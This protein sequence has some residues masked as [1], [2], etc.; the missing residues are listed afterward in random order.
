MRK[1]LT[2]IL[3]LQSIFLFSQTTLYVNQNV[4]GGLQNGTNWSDA[5][6][7]LQQALSVTTIGDTIWVAKGIYYPTTTTDRSIFF[8]LKNG[9]KMYGGF[10][11]WE[12]N[13]TQRDIELNETTLS[14][15][16]GLPQGSDNSYHVLYGE[17]LDS[18][19]VLDGFVI[20]KGNA[21]GSGVESMGGGL[22]LRPSPGI[23]NT[24]PILQN[25]RFE[26]NYAFS[27]GAISCER[28]DL[29]DNFINP[30]IINCQ[31]ISNR[32]TFSG[33]A[34]AKIGPA[35]LGQPFIM[36]A[37]VFSKNNA[38]FGDGG[39]VF[40]SRTE[41]ATILRHCVFEKDTGKIALGGGMH[42]AS[43]YEDF[44]T[45][46]T[47]ILDSCIFK[48]NIATMGGGF[49]YNDGSS[50]TNPIPF[51]STLLGCV[52]E[53]NTTTNG[54]GAAFCFMGQAQ[55]KL[56][57][58]VNSC[59][60]NGNLS[61]TFNITYFQ[62]LK[63]SNSTLLIKNCN[64]FNNKRLENPSLACF[65]IE[66]GIGGT[67]GRFEAKIENCL[68]AGNGGGISSLCNST[69]GGVNTYISNCTFYNNNEYIF[70][71]S[72]YPNFNG[73]DHYA[74]TYVNNCVIW[75][76]EAGLWTMFSDNDFMI[77]KLDG[78]H[79]DNCLLSL[80]SSITNFYPIFGDH[81][82]SET[83]PLFVDAANR[84]FRLET[85]SPAVN[86]G[87]NIIVDTMNILTDLDGN[88]RIRFDTVDI[89]AYESQDP[90]FTSSSTAPPTALISAVLSPNPV[91]PGGLLDIQVSG[92]E[93]LKVE[94]MLRDAYGRALTSGYG[95]GDI[96]L[97]A[98]ST[99]GVYFFEIRE[100][101][102]SVWL[103]L[104]VQY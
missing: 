11:G 41:Y 50:P 68:F 57:M 6:P 85:C 102:R 73:V 74:E 19:T 77:Q 48:E 36:E 103:K 97:N 83:D 79:V 89:G 28:N 1:I 60:F 29:F 22:V 90:C 17:G 46:A 104:V 99:P 81:N 80:D 78:Y 45:G 55:S 82:I 42:F 15:N 9:V 94:W 20:T 30:I 35:L 37:C 21:N 47:L 56:S 63:A 12:T 76:P 75:E 51:Q 13:L 61:H 65:P 93:H 100:G 8:V 14:G 43:G 92:I 71:K 52:F 26:G 24:R 98:P 64:Y 91:S 10:L 33:G 18:T 58:E 25:C 72:Y 54:F 96:Q 59:L 67:G 69:G 31:F 95:G 40:I 84:D 53:M 34:I 16:I 2:L 101:V 32:S 88:P 87:N 70:N 5:Y 44:N 39:G 66:F 3:A 62:G 38:Q 27:G 23:Y 7:D 4:Q 86:A 49:Y